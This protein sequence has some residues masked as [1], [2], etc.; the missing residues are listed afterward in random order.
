MHLTI[1]NFFLKNIIKKKANR[2]IVISL[3][4]KVRVQPIAET[5]PIQV[6]S[7]VDTVVKPTKKIT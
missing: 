1:A 3:I 2:Q 7:Y 5:L 4:V 6:D